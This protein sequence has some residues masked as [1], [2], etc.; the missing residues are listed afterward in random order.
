MGQVRPV[1]WRAR[2]PSPA[3]HSQICAVCLVFALAKRPWN[4]GQPKR[5]W[6]LSV[7]GTEDQMRQIHP[8]QAMLRPKGHIVDSLDLDANEQRRLPSS[9]VGCF[10]GAH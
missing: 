6:A 3:E 5:R 2:L 8:A 7:L 10:V 1:I 9:L 4:G